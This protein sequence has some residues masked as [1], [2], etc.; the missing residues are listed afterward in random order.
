MRASNL[1]AVILFL[2][3]CVPV[4][5]T[6][7]YDWSV[8]CDNVRGCTALGFALQGQDGEGFIRLERAGGS[9]SAGNVSLTLFV[10]GATGT[11]SLRLT[12][13]GKPI[14]GVAAER[15]APSG[16]AGRDGFTTEISPQELKPFI[17][18]LRKGM[19]L[20]LTAADGKSTV[21]LSLRGA[22]AALVN[23]DD[24]QGR[25]GTEAALIRKEDKIH[26]AV[27]NVP[28]F[29]SHRSS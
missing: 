16:Q 15:R 27:A 26:V 19:T 20:N 5:A 28:F 6:D 17:A 23:I 24:I 13:D 9:D 3:F 7:F 22:I 2:L 21:D 25:V 1:F 14:E 11:A 29:A 12:I 10:E 18:A 8:G 4:H